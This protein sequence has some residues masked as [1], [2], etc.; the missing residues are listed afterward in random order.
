MTDEVIDSISARIIAA[1]E[2][3]TGGTLRG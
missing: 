1:V 3:Q 2:K